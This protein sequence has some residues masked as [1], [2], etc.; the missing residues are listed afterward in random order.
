MARR[1]TVLKST[2]VRLAT[3][4]FV[5]AF[6]A[7]WASLRMLNT[8][9]SST[10]SGEALKTSNADGSE[11]STPPLQGDV[12]YRKLL[13][14][15]H[16]PLL[17]GKTLDLTLLVSVRALDA[18]IGD[19]WQ[20]RIK[21]IRKRGRVPAYYEA[22]S[23]YTDATVFA[24][25]AGAVMWA[26]VYLPER[27][28]RAYNKWIGEAAQVDQRLV[29]ALRKARRGEFVYGKET[30]QASMLQSMCRDYNWPLVWGD[31]AQTVPMPCEMVHM[32]WGPSCH[33]HAL[34][35]FAR[36]FKFSFL[37]YLP[38]QLLV[39]ARHP[40]VRAFKRA[41]KDAIR[42]SAFLGACISTFYYSVCLSRTLLGPRIFGPSTI[43][44]MMWDSGLCVGAG[45]ILCGWSILVEAEK[46]RQEVA[47]FVAPRAAATLLP[48]RYEKKVCRTYLIIRLNDF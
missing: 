32:G 43:T 41:V 1:A 14:P 26:W 11:E 47:F 15:G 34:V 3:S 46:R 27:L 35:R 31:P 40:S 48:R 25:S 7:S 17:A 2:R 22:I 30:G 5:A 16:R 4:R 19:L 36:A 9:T 33:Y 6:I 13:I 42:S 23:H 18:V 24:A 10:K 45:C 37:M 8:F 44:P 21:T 12:T 28:P 39:K 20:R 38:L 29:E